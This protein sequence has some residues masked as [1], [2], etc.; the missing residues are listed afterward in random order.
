MAAVRLTGRHYHQIEKMLSDPSSYIVIFVSS[1][2]YIP[3]PP[4]KDHTPLSFKVPYNTFVL[5]SSK[6]GMTSNTNHANQ[7]FKMLQPNGIR[8]S[9][10][11]FFGRYGTRGEAAHYKQDRV[12]FDLLQCAFPHEQ[13]VNKVLSYGIGE[14]IA[15]KKEEQGWGVYI[16]DPATAQPEYT[17]TNVEGKKAFFEM[18]EDIVRKTFTI[19]GREIPIVNI[20]KRYTSSKEIIDIMEENYPDRIKLIFFESCA[21]VF[22]DVEDADYNLAHYS[23][24]QDLWNANTFRG[25]GYGGKPE[26]PSFIT[27]RSMNEEPPESNDNIRLTALRK[28]TAI[29]PRDAINAAN[30][31]REKTI[32]G[33]VTR[34]QIAAHAASLQ[35]AKACEGSS[36]GCS[37]MGGRRRTK[38]KIFRKLRKARFT[39]KQYR[40]NQLRL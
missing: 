26:Y 37:V 29:P 18:N 24:A 20:F 17:A 13:A 32:K 21:S 1:H 9:F 22:D 16:L 7:F 36:K 31:L 30:N 25:G 15:A 19:K 3:Q 39:R 2:G 23:A 4:P 33:V 35:A 14:R 12:A 10:D 34:S 8:R 5:S 27:S 40:K 38:R 11:F 28:G 6:F